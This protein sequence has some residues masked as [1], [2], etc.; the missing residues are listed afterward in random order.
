MA[1]VSTGVLGCVVT[2]KLLNPMGCLKA[3]GKC[4]GDAVSFFHKV[5]GS[6]IFRRESSYTQLE[7][8][9]VPTNPRTEL[10]QEGRSL[11]A[12]AVAGWQG[13]S[14]DERQ[15]WSDF[16]KYRRRHPVMSG[17]NLYISRFLLNGGPPERWW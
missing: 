4:P 13:L 5:E 6:H 8:D 12:S 10:Q 11:F 16:Q 3:W 2:M 17:Y 14:A 9:Y 1:V 15:S 7:K